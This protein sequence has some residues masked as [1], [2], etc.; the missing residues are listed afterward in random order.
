VLWRFDHPAGERRPIPQTEF[1]SSPYQ[2]AREHVKDS[3]L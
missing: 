3:A 1:I 2:R